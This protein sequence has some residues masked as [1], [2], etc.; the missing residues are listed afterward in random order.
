MLLLA[1]P[2][3]DCAHSPYIEGAVCLTKFGGISNLGYVDKISYCGTYIYDAM[4][5]EW[6]GPVK[7]DDA[8]TKPPKL[9]PLF[10]SWYAC[11]SLC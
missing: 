10:K 2:T 11:I 8:S 6:L 3:F 4:M 9:L 5:V 7:A 1:M